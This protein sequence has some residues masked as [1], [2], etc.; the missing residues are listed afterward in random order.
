MKLKDREETDQVL[1]NIARRKE[2]Q[3]KF[4]Y[5]LDRERL[6]VVQAAKPL[7]GRILEAGTGRGHLAVN[8]ARSG[9]R[10]VSF[11]QS[12]D[13]LEF[14]RQNLEANHLTNLVELRQENGEKLSFPDGSFDVI[15]AVNLI[16]HL[17]NPYQVI[18]ELRRVLAPAGKLIVSDFNQVGL[19][20]MAEIH[21]LEGDEH[22]VSPVGIEE[23]GNCLKAKGLMVKK[24]ET[25]F[26]IILVAS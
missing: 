6:A 4:G 12:A 11:D 15:F 17:K 23:V 18:G 16:H 7:A 14:A 10:L 26:Q 3:A 13:Q 1:S 5:D 21:R 8:L 24:T 2:L 20:M 22:E 19:A 9:Y 25:N